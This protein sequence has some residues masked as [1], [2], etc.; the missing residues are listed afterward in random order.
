MYGL[1]PDIDLTFLRGMELAKVCVSPVQVQF[2]FRQLGTT[3]SDTGISAEIG[4]T[5]RHNGEEDEWS[6][7]RHMPISASCSVLLL[8]GAFVVGVKGE[9]DG[10]LEIEFSNGDSLTFLD[11]TTMY[12]AYHIWHGNDPLIVV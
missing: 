11:E 7:E 8:I 10:T 1:S 12:E 3:N 2:H 9:S 4:Y 5:H 6:F